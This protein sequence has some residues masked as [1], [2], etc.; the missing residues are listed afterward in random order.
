LKIKKNY[1]QMSKTYVITGASGNI[2]KVLA[3]QLLDANQSVRAIA[4]NPEKLSDLALKGA[5]VHAGDVSDAAFMTEAMAGADAAFLMIPPN[6]AAP[7]ML[8][9][10]SA[11]TKAY[12]FAVKESGIKN[13]VLLSSIGAHD[14][15]TKSVI[16]SLMQ[17]ENA[18][19]AIE[20]VN[21]LALRPSYFME[22]LYWQMGTIQ[23]MG[24][25]GAAVRGDLVMPMIATRDIAAYAAKR[26]LALDFTGKSYQDL[27]G[28]RDV[29]YQ[30]ATWLIGSAI[31]KS[32]LAYVTFPYDQAEQAMAHMMSADAARRMIQLASDMNEGEALKNYRRD[33]EST[34][35]TS[36]EEFAQ[37]FGVAYQHANT[38]K[39]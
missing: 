37:W 16:Q 38:A 28:S 14:P 22:N 6:L 11:I 18:F 36:I 24:I 15:E 20:G 35:P 21:V 3:A 25:M 26:M 5:S 23:Q 7:N 2:G 32:D 30:E 29:T 39:V 12:V 19:A 33:E 13:I 1:N 9:H 17:L 27:L 8:E 4:R 31:G 10:G 34:T